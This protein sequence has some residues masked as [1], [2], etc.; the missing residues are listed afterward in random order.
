MLNHVAF[1]ATVCL[2][3]KNGCSV[4]IYQGIQIDN[5]H[6]ISIAPE[7]FIPPIIEVSYLS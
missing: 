2:R 6:T 1:L 7:L 3:H 5:Q 4:F